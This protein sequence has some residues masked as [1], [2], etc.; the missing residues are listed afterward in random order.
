MDSPIQE[1]S[2]VIFIKFYL[3]MVNIVGHEWALDKQLSPSDISLFATNTGLTPHEAPLPFVS[4]ILAVSQTALGYAND[5]QEKSKYGLRYDRWFL[6]RL[7]GWFG[8]CCGLVIV[9]P[10]LWERGERQRDRHHEAAANRLGY[11]GTGLLCLGLVLA[12][13]GT[14]PIVLGWRM[15]W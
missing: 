12:G 15:F 11:L 3:E 2:F 4:P 13:L 7:L 14:W 9:G 5:Y 10:Y 6:P 1:S 8:L